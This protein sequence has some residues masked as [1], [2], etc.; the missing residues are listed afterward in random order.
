MNGRRAAAPGRSLCFPS[1]RERPPSAP[2]AKKKKAGGGGGG[3][4]PTQQT[5][6][7]TVPVK[8]LFPSGT[9]PEGEWQS[10]NEE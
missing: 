9:F 4:V 2:A 8:L 7:P 5:V 10:Y 1:P 6:P 3:A